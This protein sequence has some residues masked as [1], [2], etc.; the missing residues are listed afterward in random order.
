[1]FGS[2]AVAA[3]PLSWFQFAPPAFAATALAL[4]FTLHPGRLES[5]MRSAGQWTNA[6]TMCYRHSSRQCANN[7]LPVACFAWT[8]ATLAPS[9]NASAGGL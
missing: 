1:M 9:T 2:P 5:A 3:Q 7:A 4:A 8:N 6:A